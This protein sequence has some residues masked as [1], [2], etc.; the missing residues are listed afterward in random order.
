MAR[1]AWQG[2][3]WRVIV[4][5]VSRGRDHG[6]SGRMIKSIG[7]KRAVVLGAVVLGL[8]G[9][10]AALAAHRALRRAADDCDDVTGIEDL[11][12]RDAQDDR[13]AP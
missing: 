7:T 10:V 11:D 9:G 6:Y 1:V 12:D 3:R 2:G 8:T 5:R 4:V 13:D